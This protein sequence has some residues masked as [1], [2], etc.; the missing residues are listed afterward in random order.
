M[1]DALRILVVDQNAERAAILEDGLREAGYR[2]VVVVREVTHL[3]RRIVSI[4]PD[5]IFID[6][7]DPNRDVLEQMFQVSRSVPRPV[8]MFV[9]QSDTATI[10][11]AINAGVATYIVDG[12]RKERIKPILDT[13]ISRFNAYQKLRN[14][15][16]EARQALEDR[17]LIER[18]KGVLMSH[19]GMSEAQAYALLRQRAMNDHR[20]LA[21]VARAIIAAAATA[22]APAAP[23]ASAPAAS[24]TPAT[25]KRT[26]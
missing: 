18:A 25:T 15:L 19:Q 21:D 6:L 17:K 13:T 12:L 22:T 10:E 4:D 23:A 11:E 9:D 3:L 16:D 7:E 5:V 20:R 14:E 1:P 8:A 2:N 24:A 26:T